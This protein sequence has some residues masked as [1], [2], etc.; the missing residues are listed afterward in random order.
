ME[1]V[2]DIDPQKASHTAVAIDEGEDELSSVKVRASPGRTAPHLGRA[3]READRGHR[4]RG[5]P[6][7]GAG[8]AARGPGRRGPRRPGGL[9]LSDPGL[10]RPACCRG[11]PLLGLGRNSYYSYRN[12]SF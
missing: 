5:W 8:P 10:R 11:T 4:A 7:S 9:G 6:R 1:V 2:I 12:S 3:L